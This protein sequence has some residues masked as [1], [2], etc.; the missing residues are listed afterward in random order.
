MFTLLISADIDLDTGFNAGFSI[1]YQY[2]PYLAAEL[3][4]EY[5]SNDSE[6][7]LPDNERFTSGNYASN[8]FHVNSIYSFSPGK[9]LNPYVGAGIS[10]VQEID[11]DL[12][13]NGSEQSFSADGDLGYQLFAGL[14]YQINSL[15]SLNSEIRY[16]HI[17]NID[18]KGENVTGTIE[19]IDYKPITIQF[20][21]KYKF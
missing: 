18:L 12:E 21:V 2:T 9:R 5:R 1:G 10:W 14:D 7:T 6:V 16:G 8:I 17:S 11:I 15:W 19:D 20:G 4:W 13:K 3:A